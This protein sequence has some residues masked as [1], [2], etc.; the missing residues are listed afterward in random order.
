MCSHIDLRG[1]RAAL[2]QG[3]STSD[4]SWDCWRDME[5]RVI[6]KWIDIDTKML[7]L[8]CVL[9]ME[10]VLVHFHNSVHLEVELWL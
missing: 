3:F 9:L 2:K 8:F 5:P 6:D 7:V 4:P 1:E 10:N